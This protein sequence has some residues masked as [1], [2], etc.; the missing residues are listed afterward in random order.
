MKH[1]NHQRE[2]NKAKE[3]ATE[4]KKKG[5][6]VILEPRESDLPAELRELDFEPD[7]IATSNNINLVIEVKTFESIKNKK[8][9][10]IAERIKLIEGWDFELI[11]TNPKQKYEINN[12]TSSNSYVD[13]KQALARAA[14]FLDTDASDEYLDAALLLIWGAVEN[15]LRTNYLT[16]K[17]NEKYSMPRVLIRD[18][19]ILGIIGKND[20]HFLESMMKKRNE[21][22][23]GIL[24]CRVNKSELNKL[25]NLGMNVVEQIA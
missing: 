12:T 19:V 10:D 14:A 15:A 17:P 22:S 16:Y 4:Y 3:I 1:R 21:L 7:I 8:L 20:Q 6:R 5:F 18:A 23:H 24:K 25:I 11:Y 2:T 13:A 9:I